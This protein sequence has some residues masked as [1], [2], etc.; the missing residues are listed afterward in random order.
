MDEDLLDPDPDLPACLEPGMEESFRYFYDLVK[1]KVITA[2]DLKT[3]FHAVR[4]TYKQ[5]TTTATTIITL[6]NELKQTSAH[7]KTL[8]GLNC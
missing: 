7:I 6:F 5:Q 8:V 2:R 4:Q 3:L 1:A